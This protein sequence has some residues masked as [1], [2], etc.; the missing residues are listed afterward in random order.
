MEYTQGACGDS[1]HKPTAALDIMFLVRSSF[2]RPDVSQGEPGFT[3]D[4]L[5]R[6]RV[7]RDLTRPP[8]GLSHVRLHVGDRR[9]RD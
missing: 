8:F 9:T 7:D 4:Q 5:A 3:A 1:A 2:S 6:Y